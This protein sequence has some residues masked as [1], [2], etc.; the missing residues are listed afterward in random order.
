MSVELL[1]LGGCDHR[2]VSQYLNERTYLRGQEKRK[3]ENITNKKL[4]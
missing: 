3:P 4:R 1:S 2:S